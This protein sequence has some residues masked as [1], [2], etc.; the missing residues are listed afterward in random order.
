MSED[1]CIRYLTEGECLRLMGQ[2]EEAIE[3]I[4]ETEPAKTWIYWMAGNSIVVD[5]LA[6]IFKGI[7][8]DKTFGKK[9]RR[10]TIEDFL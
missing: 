7:Y 1:I 6:D 2:S 5:V 9:E 3:K 8:V 10:P 4:K